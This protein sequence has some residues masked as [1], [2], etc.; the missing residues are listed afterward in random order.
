M[1]ISGL[2]NTFSNPNPR[3]FNSISVS[4]NPQLLNGNYRFKFRVCAK[5]T[6]PEPNAGVLGQFSAPVK[7]SSSMTSSSSPKKK[8]E[9]EEKQ[10]YYLNMGHAIRCLREEFPELFYKEPSFDIYR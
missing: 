8:T 2:T 7:P 3:I 4:S 1:S 10:D 6:T 9:D 5:V